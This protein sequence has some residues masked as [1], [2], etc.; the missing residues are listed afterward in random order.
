MDVYKSIYKL[1]IR[2]FIK[3]Y[4]DFFK[5]FLC[6]FSGVYEGSKKKKRLTFDIEVT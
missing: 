5:M 1:N 3:P 4:Y 6:I 2:P